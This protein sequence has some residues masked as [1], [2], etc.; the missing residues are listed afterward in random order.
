MTNYKEID[1]AN[2][3][4]VGGKCC[5]KCVKII[6][7][8]TTNSEDKKKTKFE[9]SQCGNPVCECH[10]IKASMTTT[11]RVDK[12]F[13]EKFGICRDE[14]HKCECMLTSQQGAEVLSFLH[15]KLKEAEERGRREANKYYEKKYRYSIEVLEKQN[16]LL[17]EKLQ[18]KHLSEPIVFE[19]TDQLLIKSKDK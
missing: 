3:V 16:Q 8:V 13:D 4:Q 10:C 11:E 14:P 1:Q 17:L 6:E 7:S 18:L 15:S 9:F 5:P 19:V 2:F 12:E